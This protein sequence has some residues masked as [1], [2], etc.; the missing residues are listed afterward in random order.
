[1]LFRS[2]GGTLAS[3]AISGSDMIIRV[4]GL[5]ANTGEIVVTYGA[6]PGPGADA[7]LSAGFAEFTLRTD[8]DSSINGDTAYPL[9]VQP[10]VTV[11]APTPTVTPTN[12]PVIGGGM[13]TISPDTVVAAS[14]GNTMQIEFTNG[15]NAWADDPG[16]GTF[17]I[18]IPADWS[19]P[20]AGN[21]SAPGY[22][23]V[24]VIGGTET[25]RGVSGRIITVQAYGLPADTGKI[26]ITYGRSEERRVG[27]EC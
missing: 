6:S 12:T 10:N 4:Y 7:Q 18:T 21:I 20:D 3:R 27:K 15:V 2:K 1:M 26:R 24:D 14:S 9:F 16:Y 17:R 23:E 19:A 5:P 11:L 22:F 8:T 13:V 25:S